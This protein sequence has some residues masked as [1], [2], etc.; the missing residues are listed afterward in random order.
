MIN[1]V[2]VTSKGQITLPKEIRDCLDI[3]T[4]IYLSAYI[5][6]GK[7]ILKLLPKEDKLELIQYAQRKGKKVLIC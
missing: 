1:K 6:D 4:G 7:I 3:G 5:E 2:K